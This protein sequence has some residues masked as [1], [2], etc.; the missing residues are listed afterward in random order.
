[1]YRIVAVIEVGVLMKKDN[2][3][4]KEK[5]IISVTNYA[6]KKMNVD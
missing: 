2:H 3:S 1:M 4:T 6:Y 5:L